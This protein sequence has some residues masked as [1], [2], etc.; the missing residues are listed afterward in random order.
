MCR[1]EQFDLVY[2]DGTREGREQVVPCHRGTHSQPCTHSE[3]VRV[4]DRLVS[5]SDLRPPMQ[6][7][8]VPIEPRDSERSRL[9][10][11]SREKTR[12]P[13]E[14]I[15]LN[16][17]FWNPFSSKKKEKKE[18]TQYYVV[19]R[20]KRQEPR[21]TIIQHQPPIPPPHGMP[22]LSPVRAESPVVIPIQP[23][24]DY[25]THH[26]PPREPR[27][28]RVKPVVVHQSSDES[29]SPP[30][31]S[32]E[33]GRRTR[34]LSPISRYH[35]EKEI[36]RQRELEQRQRR[37]RIEREEREA[38][39][40]AETLA[41]LEQQRLREENRQERREARRR[42]RLAEEREARR[43]E[44]RDREHAAMVQEQE[45]LARLRAAEH[46]RQRREERARRHQEEE[47]IARRRAAD[48]DRLQRLRDEQVRRQYAEEQRYARARQANIP[49]HPRHPVFV[50]QDEDHL[51]RGERFILEAIRAE[52][53]RQFERRARR[54]RG[55]YDDDGLRRRNTVDGGQRWYGG[56]GWRRD[57]R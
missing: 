4:G 6:P 50:H 10:P 40:R 47:D 24:N 28:R 12:G 42:Q 55:E 29:A 46:A 39:E 9:R 21:P 52:N 48:H 8:I 41:I 1:I 53:Q 45:D 23:P 7:H 30:E 37:E 18:K 43:Q 26:P 2:P 33:H 36:I 31:A 19:R 13:R 49:R 20:T 27:R 17:K 3:V 34:S 35:V 56:D 15:G 32:R 57:R 22:F 25:I 11:S 44:E 14:G 51:D 5:A 54:P 16:I 38:R